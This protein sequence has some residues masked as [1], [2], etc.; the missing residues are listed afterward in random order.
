MGDWCCAVQTAAGSL[1]CVGSCSNSCVD[2][3]RTR[4]SC[5]RM[6]RLHD[7]MITL[8]DKYKRVYGLKVL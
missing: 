1:M 3:S 5:D 8:L 2:R 4:W 6:Y 7:R